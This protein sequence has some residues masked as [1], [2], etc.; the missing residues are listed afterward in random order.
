M[1]ILDIPEI[2]KKRGITPNPDAD[3]HF[4]IDK[5]ALEKIICAAEI[6]PDETVLE[7]GAGIGNLTKLL[8]KKAKKVYAIEKDFAL[9]G[10]LNEETAGLENVEIIIADA[11][12]IKLP[13]FDKLVSNLPY[14][15]CEALMKKLSFTNFKSAV[16]CVP[17]TFAKAICAKEGKKEY[18]KL[19]FVTQAFFDAEIV[20]KVAKESFYPKPRTK[21]A[22][23]KLTMKT[24]LEFGDYLVQELL[25][26]NDKKLK[27]AL[28]EAIIFASHNAGGN[29]GTKRAA[30]N[31]IATWKLPDAVLEQ[32]VAEL[33]LA[34]LLAISDRAR[35]L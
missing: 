23:L 25:R 26:E 21:S 9:S 16:V 19:S 35:N 14:Q 5:A 4:M 12:K 2:L 29:S 15:I 1:I 6:T 22:I 33:K 18:T 3:Q 10:A 17:E 27:N 28:R 31:L 7:I 34:E 8:A 24:H 13:Q 32:E 30:R 11:L 20:G